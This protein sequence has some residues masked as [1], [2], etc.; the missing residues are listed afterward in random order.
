MKPYHVTLAIAAALLAFARPSL[1][2][3]DGQ[4]IVDEV[5]SA[6]HSAKTRPLDK[7]HLS[8]EQWTEA[9]EKM[10]GFGADVPKAKIPAL[11]DYL[12]SIQTPGGNAAKK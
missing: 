12:I 3:D 8:K 4:K 9:I 1:A 2:A 5:C 10:I 7:M 6:C 11:I